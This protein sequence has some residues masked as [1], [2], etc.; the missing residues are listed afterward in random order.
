MV[1][2][3]GDQ[4]PLQAIGRTPR[5]RTDAR[6]EC[7]GSGRVD[8]KVPLIKEYSIG[9]GR[10]VLALVA[11]LAAAPVVL[12]AVANADPDP[13]P[14]PDPGVPAAAD[15]PAADPG[16]PAA[17]PK[18]QCE[19]REVGGVFVAGAT[20]PDGVTHAACQ[21]II[22]GHFYYDNYDNGAYTGT[23]VYRDGAKVPTERPPMPELLTVPT[24]LPVI[25]FPGQF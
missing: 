25:P 6:L 21:Y 8:W 13:D 15:T 5:R 4:R 11:A 17:D 19:S 14:N 12:S 2:D 3:G 7:S 18:A 20:T 16:V 9:R 1:N 24:D 22:S 10:K 23:L